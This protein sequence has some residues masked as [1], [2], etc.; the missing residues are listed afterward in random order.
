ML[1]QWRLTVRRQH[2]V[3]RYKKQRLKDMKP[4]RKLLVRIQYLKYL[5]GGGRPIKY[6]Q[7]PFKI[8][9]LWK[10][11]L[12]N[13]G[14]LVLSIHTPHMLTVTLDW[15]WPVGLNSAVSKRLDVQT[16]CGKIHQNNLHFSV[17]HINTPSSDTYSLLLS[18]FT[19]QGAYN[20]VFWIFFRGQSTV[21]LHLKS[22]DELP[23]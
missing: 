23:L 9:C 10:G 16:F 22:K 17:I 15:N 2:K 8:H 3:K 19:H 11:D 4:S 14:V 1:R 13:C 18:P 20:L 6:P 12:D 5:F 7:Y 21:Q